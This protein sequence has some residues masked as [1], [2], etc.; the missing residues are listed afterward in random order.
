M[1]HFLFFYLSLKV[2]NRLVTL[3]LTQGVELCLLCGPA[4]S[5]SV[6]E[7]EVSFHMLFH[8]RAMYFSQ[9]GPLGNVINA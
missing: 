1:S 6:L 4:P 3:Q 8:V 5:L 2:C 9:T 7:E